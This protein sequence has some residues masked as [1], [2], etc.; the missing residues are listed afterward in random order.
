[1]KIPRLHSDSEFFPFVSRIIEI[2]TLSI[3][4]L[5]VDK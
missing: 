4:K 1:L 5:E 3:R 2:P